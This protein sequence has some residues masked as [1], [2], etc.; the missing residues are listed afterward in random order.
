MPKR[1]NR[2]IELLEQGQPIY[3]VGIS[4]LSYETGRDMAGTWA[5]YINV[6]IEH[7]AF[8]MPGLG[9]F[10]R[11]LV[12]GGPTAN[13]H[14]TPAVIVDL[15]VEG[16]SEAEVRANAWMFKQALA[17]GVHGILLCHAEDPEGVRA[18]VES[19]R[20]PFRKPAE[21]HGDGRRGAGG[22]GW[23]AEIWGLSAADYLEK[24]DPWPLSP[25]GELM[26]GVKIENKRALANAEAT[27]RVQ[28]LA[29]G[30]WG[31]GDMGMSF[32][33]ADRHDPPY[34]PEIRAARSRVMAACKEAGLF[35]LNG[36]NEENIREMID[37]GVMICSG[38]REAVAQA[39]RAY[40]G[41]E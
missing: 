5:D 40:T 3:Y 27:A 24:A 9:A 14:R 32:G 29:F 25:G 19:C 18:F 36:A 20:Y 30:E 39:G 41:R 35:F 17:R 7:G 12:D 16:S 34:P 11:G 28:G 33:H 4:E 8:D 1:I 37:E 10:M 13:G 21:G 23:A 6:S 38:G 31:P 2:A 26:L 22:Q 15:P